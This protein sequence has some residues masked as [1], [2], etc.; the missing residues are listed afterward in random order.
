MNKK[1]NALFY[2]IDHMPL[3]IL[4]LFFVLINFA[5]YIFQGEKSVFPIHDQLDETLLSY[6]LSARHLF[7]GGTVFPELLGGLNKDGLQPSAPLF[8]LLYRV[9]PLYWAFVVQYLIVFLTAF[10]GMYFCVRSFTHSNIISLCIAMCFSMLPYQPIYGNSLVG[11]PLV[12]CAII[13]LTA[14]RKKLAAVICLAYYALTAHLVLSGFVVLGFWMLYIIYLMVTKRAVKWNLIGFGTLIAFYIV[15]NLS[16]FTNLIVSNT[17]F[18]SHREEFVNYATGFTQGIKEVLFPVGE[19]LH[20]PSYHTALILP[21]FVILFLALLLNKRLNKEGKT[22]LI[23]SVIGIV[24]IATVTLV[25]GV[26]SMDFVANW[27]NEQQGFFR[28]FSAQRIIW[29]YPTLWYLEA[30]I[31]IRLAWSLVENISWVKIGILIC[32]LVPTFVSIGYASYFYLNV[33]Q[34]NNGS[35]ITGYISWESYFAE[36]VMEEIDKCIGKQKDTYKIAHLGMNPTPSL[37]H[38]F[39]TV[40]GYSNNYSLAYKH[41][42]REVMKDE[43]SK[44]EATRIYFDEWGSRCYLFN[45]ISGTYMWIDKNNNATYHDLELNINKLHQL[46]CEYIFSA[47]QIEDAEDMNLEF[48]ECFESDISYW[49]VWLYKVKI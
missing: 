3:F 32:A 41:S 34:Y 20:V 15:I 7:D 4:G 23:I 14:G 40:D 17:G 38:G 24:M 27:K 37:I 12:I 13:N 8:V 10:Y 6:V 26:L 42:F 2:K 49:K 39:Y 1:L 30:A 25:Y 22:W 9:L 11:I 18:V 31:V 46:G 47:L 44:E 16:L 33:N 48:I 5:F 35:N 45:H 43:L 28:Y 29:I 19:T 36:D 21:I